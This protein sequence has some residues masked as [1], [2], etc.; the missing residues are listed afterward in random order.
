MLNDLF[1]G[2]QTKFC[3]AS[4][5]CT[6]SLPSC[7]VLAVKKSTET[8]FSLN[9]ISAADQPAIIAMHLTSQLG[10]LDMEGYN[11]HGAV[12][13]FK[14]TQGEKAVEYLL[15]SPG[16]TRLFCI[17]VL[18]LGSVLDHKQSAQ[19]WLVTWAPFRL[20]IIIWAVSASTAA[21]G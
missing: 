14:S 17:I 7:S 1:A 6:I 20:S 2:L 15:Q 12:T 5:V 19:P 4:F 9:R 8:A 16:E 18:H 10:T 11:L 3:G 21:Y 13:A